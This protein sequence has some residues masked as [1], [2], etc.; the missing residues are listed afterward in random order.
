MSTWMDIAQSVLES[1]V[2]GIAFLIAALKLR[3][4]LI[5]HSTAELRFKAAKESIPAKAAAPIPA[6][7]PIPANEWL[8]RP[9]E[10]RCP[11]ALQ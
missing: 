9:V 6:N 7:P 4:A 10:I 11:E 2:W 3:T 8:G 5:E 1:L